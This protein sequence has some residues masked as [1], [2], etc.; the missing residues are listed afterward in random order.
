MPFTSRSI[1]STTPYFN[2]ISLKCQSGISWDFHIWYL[3]HCTICSF[4]TSTGRAR[5]FV[6]SG[7]QWNLNPNVIWSFL[8]FQVTHY[9]KQCKIYRN[10]ESSQH[11][12]DFGT[13]EN[14]LTMDTKNICGTPRFSCIFLSTCSKNHSKSTQFT[15]VALFDEFMLYS[16]INHLF[17]S[18]KHQSKRVG[19]KWNSAYQLFAPTLWCLITILLVKCQQLSFQTTSLN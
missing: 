3:F 15:F 11:E 14:K 18:S 12:L 2:P 8:P 5:H 4:S 19:W 9:Y 10:W 17:H 16:L 7:C 6:P 13:M 1:G